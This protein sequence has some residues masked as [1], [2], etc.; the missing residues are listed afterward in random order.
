MENQLLSQLGI[1]WKLLLSQAIN[2]F[3]LLL[4]LTFFVYKPVI[5]IIKKRNDRIKEGLDK[6]NE[7][8]IRLKEVDNIGKEKIKEAENKSINIIKATEKKAKDLDHELGKKLEE[9]NLQLQKELQESHKKQQEQANEMVFKNAVELVK[10]TFI[11]TVELKPEAVDEALI[12]K[13]AT[14]IKN[15]SD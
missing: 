12:K 13:A 6:A 9:K 5:K 4:V 1:D 10:K 15:S 14:E 2:F 8:D 3:I 7:A 11:K